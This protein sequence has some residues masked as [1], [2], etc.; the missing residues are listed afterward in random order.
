MLKACGFFSFCFQQNKH[1]F[2][3]H[4]NKT[5]CFDFELIRPI[6]S[7]LLHGSDGDIAKDLI[8]CASYKNGEAPCTRFS[9]SEIKW[10]GRAAR[11]HAIAL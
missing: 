6:F 4:Q 9:M 2:V 3:F 1:D 10:R 5:S 7:L 8:N 11:G